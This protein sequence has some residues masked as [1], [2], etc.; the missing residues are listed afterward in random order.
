MGINQATD[1]MNKIRRWGGVHL[2]FVIPCSMSLSQTC[3]LELSLILSMNVRNL[4]FVMLSNDLLQK[5]TNLLRYK[6]FDTKA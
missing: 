4:D 2:L 6:S 1:E 5:G 3:N